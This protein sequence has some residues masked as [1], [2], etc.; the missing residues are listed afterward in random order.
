[1]Q[2]IIPANSLQVR[3]TIKIRAE[4]TWQETLIEDAKQ[5]TEEP[6]GWRYRMSQW[7]IEHGASPRVCN[8]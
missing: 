5:A 8:K 3:D 7:A 2:K 6:A 4:A 1:M